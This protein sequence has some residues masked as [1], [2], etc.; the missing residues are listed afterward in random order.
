MGAT[1]KRG[2]G[3]GSVYK[4]PNGKYRAVVTLGYFT[5][6]N[7]KLHRKTASR[8]DFTRKKDAYAYM[9]EL[10]NKPMDYEKI[11]FA[12]MYERFKAAHFPKISENTQ[13]SY[14]NSRKYF[15]VLDNREY[16]SIK[17][18]EYQDILD[19]LDISTGSKKICIALLSKM[20]VY[21]VKDEIV[22]QSKAR[23]L[24]AGKEEKKEA[25]F[26]TREEVEKIRNCTAPY[27]E[28]VLCMIYTGFRISEFFSLEVANYNRKEE[29]IQGG[30]KT[31][32]GK[33]RIIPVSPVIQPI[34]H[35]L[36]KNKIAGQIF[37]RKD[38]GRMKPEYFRKQFYYQV[39]KEAGVERKTPHACRHTFST[40]V[41]RTGADDDLRIKL[42][43][44]SSIN[45]TRH[46]THE[47][48]DE[49][50]DIINKL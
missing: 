32:A 19:N 4:L 8:S 49:L 11:T 36:T 41:R 48:V 28:Y 47:E 15:S 29:Y 9:D 25:L 42:N 23:Y 14:K 13:K 30:G 20:G 1:K 18:A 10:R 5:D 26:F 40:M 39:L 6:K 35:H 3:Q 24:Y 34:L 45:Q 43:G 37:C 44:H 7:G 50:R 16:A 2:N 46:Y 31:E 17:N 21:A 27:A 38:G 33:N 22:P 12:E